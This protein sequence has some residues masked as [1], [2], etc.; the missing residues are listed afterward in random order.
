M[1]QVTK[2][3]LKA[4]SI[5]NIDVEKARKS[6]ELKIIGNGK[7]LHK[8]IDTI[9][10]REGYEIPVRM[11]F[12]NKEHLELCEAGDNTL[13]IIIYIHGGG[14]VTDG[15]DSYER[16]CGKLSKH[17]GHLVISVDYRLAPEYKFPVGLL[18]AYEVVKSIC[19]NEFPY[20]LNTDNVTI[21]GDSAGGNLTAAICQMA[22]DKKEFTPTR[23][24]LIYPAVNNDYSENSIY[25][26]VQSK[27]EEFLLTA[28][29]M[30]DY[31][32]LY[33]SKEEDRYN[34]Y[35]APILAKDFS[36]LPKA[37]VIT[38]ENDPLRDEGE[39][40]GN[41]LKFAGNEVQIYRIE[42]AIHGYFGMGLN[43]P[44][45]RETLQLIARFLKEN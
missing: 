15:I 33:E 35:F 20:S 6:A 34:P 43:G 18:D 31:L 29:K 9:I 10:V 26:S 25:P 38:A 2:R 11:F 36:D 12:P 22:R 39:T 41:H 19:K 14:W 13:P 44:Y 45:V 8:K 23:Q 1:K 16:I 21:M 4:V 5:D 30:R 3:I 24:V 7:R 27:G 37:L 28:G 42:Q 40:Y 32:T 17:T